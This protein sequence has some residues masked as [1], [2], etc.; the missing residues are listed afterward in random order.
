MNEHTQSV[1]TQYEPPTIEVR[2]SLEGQLS[3]I[4]SN[5]PV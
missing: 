4:T 3:I 2:T 5:T 1:V